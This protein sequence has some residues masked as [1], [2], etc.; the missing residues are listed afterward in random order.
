[1]DKA[2]AL[3][4]CLALLLTGPGTS[5]GPV[6]WLLTAVCLT[7]LVGA[8][9]HRWACALL[10]AAYLLAAA[11]S[12]TALVGAPLAAHDLARYLT[13]LPT[14]QRLAVLACLAPLALRLLADMGAGPD[15]GG[16]K[17]LLAL[18]A[19]VL[20]A[21]LGLRAAQGE[22]A[23]AQLHQVHDDLRAQVQ[24]LGAS[25]AR[26]QE[27]KEVETRAATLDERTRIAREIHDGVGHQLTRALFQLRALQVVHSQQPGFLADLAEVDTTVGE[28]LDSMRRSVH[29][30]A[31]QGQ[32]LATSLSL[33]SARCGIKQVVVDCA[34]DQPPAR[35]AACLHAVA[36]ES[37]TNAAR[38]GQA[39]SARV[40]VADYPAFWRITVQNDGL[41][42]SQDPVRAS[43]G[44]G[45]R[46]MSER[47]ETLGGTLRTK[48]GPPF[49][50][51]ATIPK[52][53]A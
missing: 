2:V 3:T 14:R 37:L 27:A 23:R 8:C 35:V 34:V 11:A 25:Q 42:P 24:A 31:D 48:L 52:E 32:D 22:A 13:P 6:T 47:V 21:L 1:M 19:S 9:E 16:G 12:P 18:A 4:M 40:A 33:L 17:T 7:G 41:V 38:H 39:Q 30:L 49:T 45:L 5:V 51:L 46:A 43:N 53:P 29:A 26:L 10:P 20:A 36:Q 15:Q 50:V 44:L 28:A